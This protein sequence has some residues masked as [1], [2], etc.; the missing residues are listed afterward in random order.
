[1]TAR[2]TAIQN[3]DILQKS[4]ADW[5]RYKQ[6]FKLEDLKQDRDVQNMVFHAM[7]L[8]IQSA[9]DIAH[10]L[11]AHLNLPRPQSYRESFDI[12]SSYGYLDPQLA[13]EL[14]DLTGFRNVL[15]HVYWQLDLQ[16]VYEILSSKDKFLD[17]YKNVVTK[18]LR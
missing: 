17:Q 3:L 5:Q 10:Y 14:Q 16:R 1:M 7:L 9:I 6:K 12:L 15:V 4:L 2:E 11:I 8:C 13:Q 18:L